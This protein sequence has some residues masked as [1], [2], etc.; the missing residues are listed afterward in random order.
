MYLEINTNRL[1]LRPITNADGAFMLTLVNSP[2]WL[3]FI[4][5]R[6]VYNI[7]DAE[8][9]IQRILDNPLYFYHIIEMNGDKQPVGVISF[10]K[11]V[12]QQYFDIG[13]ALLPAYEG[14]GIAFEAASNYLSAIQSLQTFERII[15]ICVP[16]NLRSINLLKK[17][18]FTFSSELSKPNNGLSIF[19]L[20]Y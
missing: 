18:E 9:Y 20:N 7:K 12:N 4:G 14:Q 13:F 11:R 17:L 16:D 6:N 15:A 3:K 5:D 8:A 1:T 2:G 19:E 10:L